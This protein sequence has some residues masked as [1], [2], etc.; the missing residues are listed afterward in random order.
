MIFFVFT[1][2]NAKINPP[3]NVYPVCT[4]FWCPKEN[5][6]AIAT[7]AKMSL[8]SSNTNLPIPLYTISS[9]I[10]GNIA[11]VIISIAR[12]SGPE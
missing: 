9:P 2:I 1:A 10:A 11:T 6:N 5:S 8:L 3:T 7:I 4:I 12:T